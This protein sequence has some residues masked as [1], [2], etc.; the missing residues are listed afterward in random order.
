[1]A[2][3]SP[4]TPRGSPRVSRTP[5][6]KTPKPASPKS[7][8]S[9]PKAK[10]P[11]FKPKPEA[12]VSCKTALLCTMVPCFAFGSAMLFFP[13]D[14]YESYDLHGTAGVAAMSKDDAAHLSF[15]IQGWG[16][17]VL[18]VGMAMGAT[19]RSES[20]N[21]L[22][23]VCLAIA[24]YHLAHLPYFVLSTMPQAV[25]LG[26]PESGLYTTVAVDATCLLSAVLAL[27]G[28][29]KV[30]RGL[31]YKD[32]FDVPLMLWALRLCIAVSLFYGLVFTVMSDKVVDVFGIVKDGKSQ[33]SSK[34]LAHLG[35]IFPSIGSA[36]LAHALTVSA[37]ALSYD[38]HAIFCQCS[39]MLSY[40]LMAVAAN[41]VEKTAYA[42]VGFA[43]DG[44]LFTMCACTCIAVFAAVACAQAD[45][46]SRSP[47]KDKK[48]IA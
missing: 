7:P 34:V 28:S 29:Y 16:L 2:P 22:H 39:A 47:T 21:A 15:V 10:A 9:S 3:K 45:V 38:C 41:A 30:R 24:V 1:M 33:F 18:N 13:R 42:R 37:A 6:A 12:M 25:A 27:H 20:Y 17:A 19:Y 46:A 44:I 43:T 11:A 32:Y 23:N 8:K 31:R 35:P 14:F 36:Y 40:Y 26:F 5:K 4:R 48:H